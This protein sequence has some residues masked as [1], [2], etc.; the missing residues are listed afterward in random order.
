MTFF[1]DFILLNRNVQIL[2]DK[3]KDADSAIG[4]KIDYWE[5]IFTI[6]GVLKD[7]HQQS[8]K[9]DF[10]SHIYK[11]LPAGYDPFGMYALKLKFEKFR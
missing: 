11:L 5:N 8:L 7:H 3:T 10:E 4:Q 2:V 6:I 9:V 1:R